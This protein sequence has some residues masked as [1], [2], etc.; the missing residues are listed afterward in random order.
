MP[1]GDIAGR[2]G[3]RLEGSGIVNGSFLQKTPIDGISIVV[4]PEAECPEKAISLFQTGKYQTENTIA[5]SF[6]LKEVKKL[7]N[8]GLWLNCQKR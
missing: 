3:H 1:H 7:K 8:N 5:A 4:M 6:W 2:K